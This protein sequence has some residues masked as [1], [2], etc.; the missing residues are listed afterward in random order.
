MV[1]D[2]LHNMDS[3]IG[4]CRRCDY[5]QSWFKRLLFKYYLKAG[6][7]F[8]QAPEGWNKNK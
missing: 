1:F 8:C 7:I 2:K 4:E 5:K 6:D 3:R